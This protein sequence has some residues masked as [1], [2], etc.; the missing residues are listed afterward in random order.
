M[1]TKAIPSTTQ[2]DTEQKKKDPEHPNL[3]YIILGQFDAYYSIVL[4]QVVPGQGA[5]QVMW[6]DL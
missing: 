2:K 3:Q 4:G 1:N 5:I 6:P